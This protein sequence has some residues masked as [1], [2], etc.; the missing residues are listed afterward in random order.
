VNPDGKILVLTSEQQP[1]VSAIL[2]LHGAAAARSTADTGQ[3]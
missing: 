3:E 1:F 2:D